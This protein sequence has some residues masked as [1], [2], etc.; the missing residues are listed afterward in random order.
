MA[1]L[2]AGA[3]PLLIFGLALQF[4]DRLGLWSLKHAHGLSFVF[5]AAAVVAL[6]GALV[7]RQPDPNRMTLSEKLLRWPAQVPAYAIAAAA[8]GSFAFFWIFRQRLFLPPPEGLGD[9]LDLL[10]RIPVFTTLFGYQDSFDEILSLYVRSRL[11]ALLSG[12][13]WNAAD[14][15]ALWSCLC[16]ALAVAIT[17]I[18][19]R[20]EG[21]KVFLLGCLLLLGVP[22]TQL[23]Y[24]YVENYSGAH[25]AVLAVL[26]AGSRLLS[27]REE[28]QL[29]YKLIGLALVAALGAMFH[30]MVACTLPAL[31]FLVWRLST[32]WLSFVK[33]A[34][35][36]GASAAVLIGC[37]WLYFLALHPY[38]IALFDA[39]LL[40]P[41]FYPPRELFSPKHLFDQAN[42][43]LLCAPAALFLL[44]TVLQ[45][46][47]GTS[48]ASAAMPTPQKAGKVSG[49]S[50]QMEQSPERWAGEQRWELPIFFG[51]C[52]ATYCFWGF[53]WNPLLGF[54]ADW[55]LLCFFA[56]P[57]HLL[58]FEICRP[59]F[60]GRWWPS[61]RPP[62]WSVALV[63]LG[64][65]FA[66]VARNAHESPQSK[67]NLQ[68]AA[69]QAQRFLAWQAGDPLYP[70]LAHARKKQYIKTRLFAFR[71]DAQLSVDE[72]AQARVLRKR[73]QKAID[74]YAAIVLLDEESFQTRLAPIWKELTAINIAVEELSKA[75][76][77]QR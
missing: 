39:H 1:R 75:P 31:A 43:W 70:R 45:L 2:L 66:W 74:A 57:L 22:A 59:A 77:T 21:P 3:L 7:R 71:A 36:A 53:V 42:L 46:A 23:Y 29:T 10:R 65:T 55:D 68:E 4:A 12:F 44:P 27:N 14:A 8:F 54:P 52:A 40:H 51:L 33:L 13:G 49:N 47:I 15:G 9:S 38:P 24:G 62:L 19:L 20:R 69:D 73:L 18:Y 11:F 41:P 6:L 60:A 67:H 35:A 76:K 32:N 17:L 72:S 64:L 58:V 30:L 25:V 56:L 48:P 16:G 28:S 37:V 61:L 34:L 26:L 50:G 63:C 5:Y